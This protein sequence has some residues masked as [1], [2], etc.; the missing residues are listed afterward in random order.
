MSVVDAPAAE[1]HAR[2][3]DDLVAKAEAHGVG[4]DEEVDGMA[5]PPA[6]DR[7]RAARHGVRSV[8]TKLNGAHL[9]TIEGRGNLAQGSAF[10]RPGRRANGIAGVLGV[11]T[12][13]KSRADV[14]ERLAT[15]NRDQMLP[16]H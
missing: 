6:R 13:L 2:M 1:R 3:A 9:P 8:M 16:A 7:V 14:R 5:A 4:A 12:D 10:S 15:R 11:D